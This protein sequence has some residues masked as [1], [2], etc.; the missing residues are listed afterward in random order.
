MPF[1]NEF[2]TNASTIYSGWRAEF[3]LFLQD[4]F[5][6]HRPH[7]GPAGRSVSFGHQ[8]NLS[9]KRIMFMAHMPRLFLFTQV[10]SNEDTFR[11][12]EIADDLPDRLR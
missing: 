10:Q 5:S 9:V 7:P 11:I 8:L 1:S 12:G 3:L 4:G 6:V 2:T